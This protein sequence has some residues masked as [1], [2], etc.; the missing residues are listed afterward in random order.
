MDFRYSLLY[1]LQAKMMKKMKGV[2]T[3]MHIKEYEEI[4]S[5]C[6]DY[7]KGAT[8]QLS[9][10]EKENFEVADFGL[11]R[12]RELGLQL[13]VY[14]NTDRYCAKELIL[15][16]RQT[17]PEHIHPPVNGSLGK[18][19]TFRCRKGTAYL[20]VPGPETKNPKAIIP[21]GYEAYLSVWNEIILQPG[22][23]FTIQ[24]NTPHW[25]QA[26]D[27]GAIVSEF[28][29]TSTDENDIFKDP[30]IKRIPVITD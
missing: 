1:S 23:Q 12:I 29:S 5:E 3:N 15:L 13:V 21:D 10:K 30:R 18:E 8:I 20:Y 2:S 24:P 6:L 28:S 19:E 25:F 22:E 16:P 17:C 4:K 26:G 9:E 14:I 7:L 11:D 27:H